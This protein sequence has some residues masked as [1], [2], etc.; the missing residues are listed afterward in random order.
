MEN[1]PHW[2]LKGFSVTVLGAIP[3]MVL[4]YILNILVPTIGLV[5]CCESLG[6]SYYW[7]AYWLP[8]AVSAVVMAVL[9]LAWARDPASATFDKQRAREAAKGTTVILGC[10]LLWLAKSGKLF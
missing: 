8:L 2:L 5:V 4:G 3:W 6:R 10:W 9:L 7:Y 1:E